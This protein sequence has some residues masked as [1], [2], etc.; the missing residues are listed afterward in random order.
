MENQ[1]TKKAVQRPTMLHSPEKKEIPANQDAEVN[2][3][4]EEKG[5]GAGETPHIKT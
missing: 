5:S 3:G 4:R 2:W 1:A